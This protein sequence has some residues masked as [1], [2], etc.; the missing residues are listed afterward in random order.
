MRT[1]KVSAWRLLVLSV[2][3]RIRRRHAIRCGSRDWI[4]CSGR[5]LSM[6]ECVAFTRQLRRASEPVRRLQEE[7]ILARRGADRL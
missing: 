7:K 2:S 4:A 1:K 6:R 5:P 3:G